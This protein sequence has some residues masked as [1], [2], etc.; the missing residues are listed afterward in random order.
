MFLKA[1]NEV[2]QAF[3]SE[4]RNRLPSDFR[5]SLG[6]PELM[7]VHHPTTR[8]ALLDVVRAI[9][10]QFVKLNP[11]NLEGQGISHRPHDRLL[12]NPGHSRRYA[13]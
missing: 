11:P 9:G 12:P 6:P 1:A 7:M 2:E 3:Y 4:G 13:R 10:D 5:N 8:N